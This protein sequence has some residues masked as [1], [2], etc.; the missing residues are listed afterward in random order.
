MID[1]PTPSRSSSRLW[2]DLRRLPID[3][4]QNLRDRPDTAVGLFLVML[5]GVSLHWLATSLEKCIEGWLDGHPSE[6]HLYWF[7]AVCAGLAPCLTMLAWGYR[8]VFRE[9]HVRYKIESASDPRPCLI[10]FVSLQNLLTRADQVPSEGPLILSDGKATATLGRQNPLQDADELLK[11]KI[12]WNWEMLLRGLSPHLP[13]LRRVYL[14]GSA[15]S[16][17]ASGT[18]NHLEALRRLLAPYLVAANRANSIQTAME[19][20]VPWPK[21]V[22]FEDF[23]AV[24]ETLQDIRGSLI[25]EQTEDREFCVDITGGQ[26]PTS[27]AAGAFTMNKDVVLQY[28]QTN[29]P[30]TAHMHDVRLLSAPESDH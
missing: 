30:K 2:H 3:T 21:A 8:H 9:L 12:R 4:W 7:T 15:D 19:M 14:V 5:A 26:K 13:K 17:A 27:A 29:P 20:I 11:A 25:G 23:K 22:D 28:V 16:S 24:D 1:S 10:L 18:H 6:P